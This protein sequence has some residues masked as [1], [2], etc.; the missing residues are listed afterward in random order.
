MLDN[1]KP[2][3]TNEQPIRQRVAIALA[4]GFLIVAAFQIALTFGAPLGAAAQG[5]RNPGQLPDAL[6]VVTGIQ[7]VVW[8]FAALVV[9]ARGGRAVVSVPQALSRVGTWVLVGLLGVGA[10]MN[11]ASSSPWERFGWGPFTVV[12]FIL[13]VVLARSELPASPAPQASE[14]A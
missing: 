8:L 7:S 9:L 3:H 5:G 11:V 2:G 6:R 4:A 13:G 10:V 14:I 1:T 12:L